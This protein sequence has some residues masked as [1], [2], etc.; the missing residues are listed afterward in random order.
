MSDRTELVQQIAEAWK[1][2][3]L[4]DVNRG[5]GEVAE[6]TL[7]EIKSL[8]RDALCHRLGTIGGEI[9]KDV[10]E[11]LYPVIARLVYWSIIYGRGLHPVEKTVEMA[12]KRTREDSLLA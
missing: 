5:P 10:E 8:C 3:P 7:Q 6:L 2:A 9:E 11:T 12:A 1:K 4:V